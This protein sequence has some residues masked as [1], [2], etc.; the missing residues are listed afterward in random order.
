MKEKLNILIVGNSGAASALCKKLYNSPNIGKL[1]TAPGFC[2]PSDKVIHADIREDD[3]TGL[4]KF[5]VE[6][7]ID[8]TIPTSAKALKS[9]IVSFFLTNGQNIFGPTLN[10]CQIALNKNFGKK[11]LYK[12]HAQ[13]SKFG[14]FDKLQQA[15]EYLRTAN[16]PVTIKSSEHNNTEDM[17]VCPTT[18]L[19][20]EFLDNLF[21]KNETGI[22]IE[23]YT[24]GHTFTIYYITDGYSAIPI[25]TIANYKFM[26]DGDG[27]IYTN[28]MGCFAPDY[29]VSEIISSRVQNIVRNTLKALDKKGSPY[30]GIIGV[31]CTITGE[32]KFYV[33]EFK[34]FLQ[35]Y[36]ASVV[37]NSIDDNLIKIFMACIDGLFADEYEEIQQN[38][39]NSISAVVYSRQNNKIIQGF[40]NIEDIE[41][42]DFINLKHTTDNKYLTIKGNVFTLTRNASTLTRAKKYLYEDLEQIHFDGIKYRKDLGGSKCYSWE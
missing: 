33:N 18:A 4:L 39:L 26:E 28:G 29:K 14:I 30:I 17:L 11:F 32:D 25:S 40:D 24:C 20:R 22:L 15:E 10:A 35:N 13:T 1:Y 7:N 12:I 21:S 6:N 2:V 37:L 42:I 9:D 31:E 38:N 19:A 41:N 23:E 3:L 36:D 8:L 16:F 27:G 5:A 34:P